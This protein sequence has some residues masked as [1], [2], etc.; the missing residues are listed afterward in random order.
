M[1]RWIVV[2]SWKLYR[3]RARERS[4]PAFAKLP[5]GSCARHGDHRSFFHG[6]FD[7]GDTGAFAGNRLRATDLRNNSIQHVGGAKACSRR[8]WVALML[9]HHPQETEA[10][11][12]END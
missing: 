9:P 5:C 4:H 6:L 2:R 11:R 12:S 3:E 10:A 7:Y 1:G 8:P